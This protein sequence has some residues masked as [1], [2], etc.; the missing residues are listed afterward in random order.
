MHTSYIMQRC[1]TLVI[2]P[3]AQLVERLVVAQ[4]VMCASHIGGTL[5]SLLHK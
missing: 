4:K 1:I 5:S 2:P 3:V